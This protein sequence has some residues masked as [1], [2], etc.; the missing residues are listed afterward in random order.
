MPTKLTLEDCI[1]KAKE[2]GGECLEKCYIDNHFKMRWKC[3][4]EHTWK[5]SFKQ[6]K[7]GVWCKECVKL[8]FYKK[9]KKIAKEK[10]GECLEDFYYNN[11]VKMKWK[12]KNNHIWHKRFCDIKEGSWCN[13]CI[14]L[15]FLKECK[16]IAKNNEGKCLEN[17]FIDHA[18]KMKWKCKNNHTWNASFTYIKQGNWCK[19]CSKISIKDCQEYAKNKGGECLE[20]IYVNILVKMKWKCKNN[21]TWKVNFSNIKYHNTWCPKCANSR[22]ENL[23]RTIFEE[24]FNTL[25]PSVRPDFLKYKRNL[26]LD[27]YNEELKIA[28][29]YNGQQHYKHTPFFHKKGIHQF[30]EQQKRDQFKKD[31]CHELGIKLIIIPYTY[32]LK[33]EKKLREFIDEQFKN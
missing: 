19:E 10:G 7:N 31:K 22:T 24:K 5:N 30:N 18:V 26:E 13:E 1:Q 17:I 2:K 15:K 20:N 21:H 32:N 8:D 12:C 23:I 3:Y 28:F 4:N 25:F 11:R 6:V 16:N 29:E 33:N 9:C 27:G 14:K